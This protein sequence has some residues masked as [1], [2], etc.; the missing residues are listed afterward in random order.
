[1][2]GEQDYEVQKGDKIAQLIV[3]RIMDEEI[4]LVKELDITERGVEGF[5]SSDTEMITERS[6]QP[7]S[8]TQSLSEKV[9][10]EHFENQPNRGCRKTPNQPMMTKQVHTG[11]NLLTN[12]FRKVTR[13]ADCRRSHNPP[14]NNKIHISEIRQ[15]EFRRA[16]RD[17]ETTGIVKF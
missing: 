1:N 14:K 8:H 17:G 16:Y 11:A 2:Y 12:Q 4:V 3:E 5:G 9:L 15:K 6:D 13:P 7:N 10:S